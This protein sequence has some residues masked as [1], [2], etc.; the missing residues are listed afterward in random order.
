MGRN[1]KKQLPCPNPLFERLLQEWRDEARQKGIKLQHAYQKPDP[2]SRYTAWSS[3]STLT[4][5][6]FIIKTSNPAKYSITPEGCRLAEKL[7]HVGA[8][9][10]SSSSAVGF[11]LAV[12]SSSTSVNAVGR[13]ESDSENDDAAVPPYPSLSLKQVQCIGSDDQHSSPEFV[14]KP[15]TIVLSI[16]FHY[17]L[18]TGS[19]DV[20]LCVDFIE[21]TGGAQRSRKDALV[22]ELTNNGVDFDVRKLQVGD[23]A[24]VAREKTRPVPGQLSLPVGRELVLDYIIERKRMDDLNHSII[25]GRFREQ[26]VADGFFIKRTRDT[27]ESVAYLTLMTR[28]IQSFYMGKTLIACPRE[29][30][31]R[32]DTGPPSCDVISR[33]VNLM[34]YQEFSKETIKNKYVIPNASGRNQ[35]KEFQNTSSCQ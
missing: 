30:L 4:K 31:E 8:D 23:F 3:M 25:D 20:V 19:F 32:L 29:K 1:S 10:S 35:C 27:K 17:C 13:S 12:G 6:G 22:K 15:G 33:D 16:A 9:P 11:R 21:T 24:W 14:L 18:S 5:K 28:F 2:G 34:T 26:K 7:Q